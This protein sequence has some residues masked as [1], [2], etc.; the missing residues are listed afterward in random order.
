VVVQTTVTLEGDDGLDR[1][2]AV[3]ARLGAVRGEPG[4]AEP[5]L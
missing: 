3:R 4:G 2:R 1:R 5:A